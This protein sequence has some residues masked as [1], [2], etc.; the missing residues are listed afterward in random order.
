MENITILES[1]YCQLQKAII[2]SESSS[3]ESLKKAIFNL[4]EEFAK[5]II[6]KY[7]L[8]LKTIRTPMSHNMEA[9]LPINSRSVI[10]TTK[11]DFESLGMGINNKIDNSAW[12]KRIYIRVTLLHN[13]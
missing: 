2:R 9:F 13:I 10:I 6:E 3:P 5:S 12:F 1:D 11:D 4:G 8:S 7:D